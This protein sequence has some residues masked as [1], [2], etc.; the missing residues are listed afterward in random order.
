MFLHYVGQY[1]ASL[2]ANISNI[3]FILIFCSETP[4]I[5]VLAQYNSHHF[6]VLFPFFS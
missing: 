6:K 3:Y 5:W 4:A 1:L 2:V